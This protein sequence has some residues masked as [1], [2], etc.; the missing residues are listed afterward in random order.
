MNLGG[1][2]CYN[3]RHGLRRGSG[4]QRAHKN[5]RTWYLAG[6]RGVSSTEGKYL[7]FIQP[8]QVS[9]C[10]RWKILHD[11]H[12]YTLIYFSPLPPSKSTIFDAGPWLI[13]C[14]T[15]G[16]IFNIRIKY[17]VLNHIIEVLY[18]FHPLTINFTKEFTT[19]NVDFDTPF[20][21]ASFLKYFASG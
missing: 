12:S 17:Q 6:G 16:I 11:E 2:Q 13:Y 15:F 8:W 10:W 9:S 18:F 7:S 14:V 4:V 20:P 3:F 19:W 5:P 21:L 1:R